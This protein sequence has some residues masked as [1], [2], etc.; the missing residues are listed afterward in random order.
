MPAP[1]INYFN[2]E[3]I[4]TEDKVFICMRKIYSAV[5]ISAVLEHVFRVIYTHVQAYN[6][7]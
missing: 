1:K 2:K 4:F 7:L 6:I 3:F 5:I